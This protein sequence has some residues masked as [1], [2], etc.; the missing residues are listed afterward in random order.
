MRGVFYGRH[1]THKQTM[2]TQ[3]RRAYELAE[4]YECTI[5]YEI[6]DEGVSSRKK[7]RKGFKQLIA[8]AYSEKFDFVVIHR[9]DRIARIPEE[10]DMIRLIMHQLN[11]PIIESETESLYD[12][13]DTI[14]RAI[15]DG[16]AK[17]EL[18]KI[19]FNT[20]GAMKTLVKN[21]L[22]TGGKAPFGYRYTP[23]E[24]GDNG[25][26]EIVE[27]EMELVKKVFELYKKNHGFSAIAEQMPVN[28]HR[29]KEWN[30]D[31]VK[32]IITNPFYA[33]YIAIRRKHEK[34][35]NS[36]RDRNEWVMEKSSLI[37]PV[38]SI[39]EWEYCWDLYMTKMKR[40]ISPKHFK[41]SFLLTSLL[42][43]ED[44][45]GSLVGKDQRTKSN[46]GKVYGKKV[47]ICKACNF[48]LNADE[49]HETAIKIFKTYQGVDTEQ[50][51]EGIQGKVE[52]EIK[53]IEGNIEDL[54][55][56]WNAEKRKLQN[57]DLEI[58]K[59]FKESET[60]ETRIKIFL[61]TKEK[62]LN[63]IH[64]IEAVIEE[65]K[66]KIKFL[67]EVQKN[68]ILIEGQL[69]NF[70][71]NSFTQQDLRVLFLYLFEKITVNNQ[72]ALKCKLRFN[73]E[74]DR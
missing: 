58:E 56:V 16:V 6:L 17:Y 63:Q 14:F 9:H 57:C 49:A 41:T 70:Y 46:Q 24:K 53:I 19:R 27:V 31:R 60:N 66:S 73:L 65:K 15:K 7:N 72:G 1:S 2:E 4:K 54:E 21:G 59:A 44:C 33:G 36:L 18:D 3:L 42:K 11:I 5:V 22:W 50:L 13:G 68:Q 45:N 37:P 26:F 69:K 64:Q 67:E 23:K 38:L 32:N 39:E 35:H 74:G 62:L 52:N 71:L 20:R 28:S 8:D 25:K 61:I 43:C 10:H 12:Y 47:Y 34:K 51:I 29:G 48:K 40:K 55:V 30:K